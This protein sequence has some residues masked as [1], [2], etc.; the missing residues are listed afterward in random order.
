VKI[1]SW[2]V[3]SVRLRLPQIIKAITIYQPD[4]LCLQETKTEDEFFPEQDFQK[5]GY[6]FVYYCGQKSYNGVAIISRIFIE[7]LEIKDYFLE[8]K[9]RAI[10]VR[11]QN[12]IELF[13]F[14]IPAGGDIPDRSTNIKF[15]HKLSFVE[16][17]IE[18]FK[19][20]DETKSTI[21]A[22]DFNIAPYEH[23]VWS[24]KALTQV[25]SH[26]D[27][28]RKLLLDLLSFGNFIDAFRQFVPYHQ[29]L[30]SW[31]SYRSP[32][33]QKSNRGRRLDHIWLSANLVEFLKI[34]HIYQ[35]T[36][37]YERPSDHALI[38]IDLEV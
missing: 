32:N 26:T 18:F 1:C 31:W 22:G 25:V 34:S 2:N 15:E 12:N 35:E 7:L 33:W 24:S 8:N 36:R 6:N 3:N 38:M 11:F 23:D 37:A 13:N 4:V 29:K 28:E 14:Y 17:L 20:R 30:Y 27:I 19:T 21:I 16:Y 9:T 5:L 10:A